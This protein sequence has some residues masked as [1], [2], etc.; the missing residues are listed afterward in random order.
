MFEP[1]ELNFYD[2]NDEVIATHAIHRVK[3]KFLKT[4]IRL[5]KEIN[6]LNNIGEEQINVLN[7]FIVEIFGNKFTADELEEK[8][9][10]IECYSVLGA[11]FS[12][13]NGLAAQFAKNPIPPSLKKK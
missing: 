13:A 6:D 5:E 3:T 7:N 12:R 10:L 4:A 11:V 8:T 1:I 9:D 2:E